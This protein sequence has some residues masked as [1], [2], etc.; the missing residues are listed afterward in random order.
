MKNRL[1]AIVAVPLFLFLYA[2]KDTPRSTPSNDDSTGEKPTVS[3]PISDSNTD[4]G[5]TSQTAAVGLSESSEISSPPTDGESSSTTKVSATPVSDG[6]S[7]VDIDS[8]DDHIITQDKAVSIANEALKKSPL[9]HRVPAQ[10]KHSV[11]FANGQF[12]ITFL[13]PATKDPIPES[14]FYA[15]VRVDAK[16][17]EAIVLGEP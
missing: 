6:D 17:G 7:A 12:E 5:K 10:A 11:K 16:S 3:I 13:R 9:A 14:G 2:C 1:L 15:M 8:G 4:K